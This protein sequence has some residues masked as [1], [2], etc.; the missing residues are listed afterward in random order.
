MR[1]YVF[2]SVALQVKQLFGTSGTNGGIIALT[3]RVHRCLISQASFPSGIN[4]PMNQEQD[5]QLLSPS[6]STAS[7]SLLSGATGGDEQRYLRWWEKKSGGFD[8]P[9]SFF[10]LLYD[11]SEIVVEA[12]RY[13][14]DGR[15]WTPE[16]EIDERYA[17]KRLGA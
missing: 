5:S 17:C 1:I 10:E 6:N 14:V 16:Y 4:E 7:A 3:L 9:G 12:A 13:V 2:A 15:E 11:E 8:E